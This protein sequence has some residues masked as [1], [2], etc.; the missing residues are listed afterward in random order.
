MVEAFWWDKTLDQGRICAWGRTRL[1]C[2]PCNLFHQEPNGGDTLT[3]RAERV[4]AGRAGEG[5]GVP[6]L[7]GK[8]SGRTK[9][10]KEATKIRRGNKVTGLLKEPR[11]L[12][13]ER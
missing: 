2:T 1:C 3:S 7:D 5:D 11:A 8:G 13:A 10:E 6:W 9:E 4:P 12:S